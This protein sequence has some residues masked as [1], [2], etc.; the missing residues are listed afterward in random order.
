[1]I[2]MRNQIRPIHRLGIIA[3]RLGRG[4][5]VGKIKP[6]GAREVRQAAE[7]FIRMQER[8]NQ[9]IT[10]RTTLLAGVSH[11]LRTPLTRMKL[12]LEM[13]DE[14]PDTLA[15][16]NDIHD[17]EQMIEGYLSFARGD[18]GEEMTR[19]MLKDILDKVIDDARRLSLIV[20]D[21]RNNQDMI[22]LWA[23]PISLGRAFNNFVTNAVHYADKL[24]VTVTVNNEWVTIIFADNGMGIDDDKMIDVLKPFVRGDT[25]RNQKT[26]GVGLGLTIANDIIISHGG[27][28][29]LS[30]SNEM[31]GLKVTVTL[32]I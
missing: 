23:K 3:E 22:T 24:S 8:I 17:M 12:Q 5:S 2:F 30:S 16:R 6:S 21:N 1:M 27:V 32:P 7:A 28:L 20:D 29:S 31:G 11:D 26:G 25:S 10:G 15:M 13:M 9:F 18:G 14:S 19:I 4:I